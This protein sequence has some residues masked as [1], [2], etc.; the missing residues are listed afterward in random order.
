M[1]RD[2]RPISCADQ[3]HNDHAAPPFSAHRSCLHRL[4]SQDAYSLSPS[5]S[6]SQ[7]LSRMLSHEPARM[8]LRICIP[9]PVGIMRDPGP[10]LNKRGCTPYI[11]AYGGISCTEHEPRSN[12]TVRLF[13]AGLS[14]LKSDGSTTLGSQTLLFVALTV[15]FRNA[16]AFGPDFRFTASAIR[17]GK[18][19]SSS[20]FRVPVLVLIARAGARGMVDNQKNVINL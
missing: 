13:F 1:H 17:Q 11:S 3:L 2:P 14:G 15:D 20:I 7:T 5:L 6:L 12:R 16:S 9:N 18:A 8:R 19:T 4:W 10:K